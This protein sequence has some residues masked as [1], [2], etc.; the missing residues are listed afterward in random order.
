MKLLFTFLIYLLNFSNTY[1]H[2]YVNEITKPFNEHHE[3]LWMWYRYIY[4]WKYANIA[5][6]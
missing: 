1:A 4:Y 3:K 2:Y 5:S 6:H